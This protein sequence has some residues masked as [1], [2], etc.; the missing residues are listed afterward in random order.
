MARPQFRTLTLHADEHYPFTILANCYPHPSFDSAQSHRVPLTLIVLHSTSFHKEALEPTV[1]DLFAFT[2]NQTHIREAWIIECP[3]HGESAVLNHSMLLSKKYAGYF[4]CE[5]YAEAAQR[6]LL[7][8]IDG[9]PHSRIRT[10]RIVGIGHSLGGCGIVFLANMMPIFT[11]LILLDPF[12]LPIEQTLISALRRK[13]VSRAESRKNTWLSVQELEQDVQKRPWDE[14]VRRL[15]LQYGLCK[16]DHP[17][18]GT[19]YTLACTREQ[20]TTMYRDPLGA[21]KP[22]QYLG[23]ICGQIP[24]HIAFGERADVV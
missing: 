17:T 23:R 8:D 5:T 10:D 3:N 6:L 18:S 14:R 21:T 15:Y 19:H 24:V 2:S 11:S 22:V 9:G 20:E 7:A 12:L 13:L 16:S 4:S 1:A